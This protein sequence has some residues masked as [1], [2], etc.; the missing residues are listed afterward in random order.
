MF[1]MVR[2]SYL[3]STTYSKMSKRCITTVPGILKLRD[4]FIT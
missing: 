1:F 2:F 4:V 3:I